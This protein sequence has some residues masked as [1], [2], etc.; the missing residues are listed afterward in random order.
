VRRPDRL[1]HGL[2][3]GRLRQRLRDLVAMVALVRVVAA[4]SSRSAMIFA[5]FCS[6]RMAS[7]SV[8]WSR[9][10]AIASSW[11]CAIRIIAA[12]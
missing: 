9:R 3:I 4:N 7:S 12:R 5:D 11:R 10:V 2:R 6:P 1:E 8:S